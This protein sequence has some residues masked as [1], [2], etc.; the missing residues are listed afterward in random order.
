MEEL[1]TD[2]FKLGG[3]VS[4]AARPVGRTARFFFAAQ[5]FSEPVL[6]HDAH[7]DAAVYAPEIRAIRQ[8]KKVWEGLVG[9][10]LPVLRFVYPQQDGD[11][12][13]LIA[14]APPRMDNAND[15][16]Q[17]VWYRVSRVAQLSSP[18]IAR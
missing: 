2:K 5:R 3:D 18:E 8:Q 15:W 14:F 11:W 4:A 9:G 12:W 13:E 6:H 16:I 10:W 7:F 1:A 17:A